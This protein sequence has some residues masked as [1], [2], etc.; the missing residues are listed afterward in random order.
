MQL[1][2]F[3][4]ITINF[5]ILSFHWKVYNN[6]VIYS[7]TVYADLFF[8][9]QT[10]VYLFLYLTPPDDL[11]TANYYELIYC[12]LGQI[13]SISSIFFYYFLFKE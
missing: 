1:I 13:L 6:I 4:I 10:I 9:I 8:S 11:E 7:F 3:I 2:L 5:I 12:F